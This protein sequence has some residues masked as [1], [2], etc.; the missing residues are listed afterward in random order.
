M[1]R[2]LVIASVLSAVLSDGRPGYTQGLE[3]FDRP[4]FHGGHSR[5]AAQHDRRA[6]RRYGSIIQASAVESGDLKKSTTEPA[7]LFNETDETPAAVPTVFREKTSADSGCVGDCG[8]SGGGCAGKCTSG[9]GGCECGCCAGPSPVFNVLLGYDSWRGLPDGGWGNYGLHTGFNLGMPLGVVSEY[10]GLGTQLGGTINAYNWAGSDHRLGNQDQVTTQGFLTLGVFRN[11]D[12]NSH[13]SFGIVQDWMFNETYGVFGEDVVLDQWR[14]LVSW[15][16]NECHEV[17]VWGAWRGGNE[18]RN[19]QNFGRVIWQ[20]QHQLNFF[21]HYKW[22]RSQADTWIWIGLPEQDR[23]NANGTLGDYIAGAFATV[24]LNE[25]L[26]M[27]TMV[28]YMHQSGNRGPAAAREVY[29]NLSIGVAFYP[30]S[31][32]RTSDVRGHRYAPRIPVANNG[33][34]LVDTSQV[35]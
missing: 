13:L 14:A 31:S 20:A 12:E 33:L 18:R 28:N 19:V 32:T 34:F 16:F 22:P 25:R 2:G 17:G 3:P 35:F 5:P 4:V 9:H 29:W 30:W 24:P 15:S 26:S 11:A 1:L 8:S 23:L 21:W 6:P 7:V 10:T 27:Y